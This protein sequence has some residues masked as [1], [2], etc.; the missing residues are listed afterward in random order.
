[1][2][3]LAN[4]R[5]EDAENE[6]EVSNKKFMNFLG[7]MISLESQEGLFDEVQ[8]VTNKYKDRCIKEKILPASFWNKRTAKACADN[9]LEV[10]MFIYMFIYIYIYIYIYIGSC[11]G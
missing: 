4:P 6:L 1:V 5:N 9:T 2:N 10:Y 11:V 3:F 7:D 8:S